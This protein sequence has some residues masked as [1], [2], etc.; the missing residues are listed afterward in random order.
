MRSRAIGPGDRFIANLSA[1]RVGPWSSPSTRSTVAT[2]RATAAALQAVADL[3]VG[4]EIFPVSARYRRGRAAARQAP[5]IDC[6]PRVR[7][8]SRRASCSDVP[9][10]VWLAELV[11]EQVL[12][13]AR[14]E[15]PH[16]VEV[17]VEAIEQRART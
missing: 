16:A 15:V 13:R 4:E 7:S 6:C 8:S 17:E 10:S 5:R 12:A 1:G 9:E 2:G 14:E 11:R 3:E